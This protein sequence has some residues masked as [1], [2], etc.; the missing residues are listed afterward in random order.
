M[1]LTSLGTAVALGMALL[2][3]SVVD[4]RSYRIADRWSLPLLAAGIGVAAVQS[5]QPIASH[6]AGALAGYAVLAVIGELH[7]R[8]RGVEGLGLGD[9]K[10]FAAAGAWLGWAALPTVLLEA[11]LLA[12]AQA[13][14][15]RLAGHR[16]RRIAFAPALSAAFWIT[17]AL[18]A[19]GLPITWR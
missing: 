8:W 3:I 13:G 14:L 19:P 5:A 10:L 12:L 18:G 4:I 11:S 9:A 17:W 6:A 15:A 16:D 1:D 2:W 7:F